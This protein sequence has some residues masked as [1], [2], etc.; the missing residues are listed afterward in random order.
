[1]PSRIFSM[2]FN[3]ATTMLCVSSAS[4]TIHIFRLV[5]KTETENPV[6]PTVREGLVRRISERSIS[7]GSDTR[8]DSVEPSESGELN[9]A[10]RKHNG[11]FA[12][13][14]RRTS[15]NVTKSFA[16]TVGGYLLPTAVSEML[17]PARDFAWFKIPRASGAGSGSV[18]S[19]VAMSSN[20]PQVMV[21]TSDGE[22]LVFNIDLEKGGEA[23]MTTQHS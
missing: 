4:E 13:M 11:T 17:E 22:F 2:S 6:S 3:I 16:A 12:G 19:V 23:V 5:A 10:M 15:Q 7:P 18:R 9:T 21:A 20:S 8:S 14:I 1:M